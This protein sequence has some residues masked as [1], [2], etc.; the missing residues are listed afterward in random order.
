MAREPELPCYCSPRQTL[1]L[2]D[3]SGLPYWGC[4]RCGG[5]RFL[6][7]DFRRWKAEGGIAAVSASSSAPP[8]QALAYRETPSS[9]LCQHC[10]LIMARYRVSSDLPFHIDRC[11]P[12]QSVWL[13]GLEWELLAAGQKLAQ[14]E[15]ILSDRWQRELQQ[16]EAEARREQTLRSRF[17]DADYDRLHEIGAW[18]ATQPKRRE[19][20][21]YLNALPAATPESRA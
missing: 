21:A 2:K 18:L 17:G 13:D 5:R 1:S 7:A 20:L 11:A 4:T 12:C 8:A 6:L 14:L 3:E 9:R 19:M 10:G 16:S 15:E